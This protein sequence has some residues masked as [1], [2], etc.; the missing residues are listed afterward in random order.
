MYP[1]ELTRITF[2]L[3]YLKNIKLD[4]TCSKMTVHAD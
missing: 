2:G 3:K 4:K 1:I